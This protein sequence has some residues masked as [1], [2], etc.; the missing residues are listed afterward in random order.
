MPQIGHLD[1]YAADCL[2][3]FNRLSVHSD[4]RALQVRPCQFWPF[5]TIFRSFLVKFA[6]IF[7]GAASPRAPPIPGRTHAHTPDTPQVC[8]K[9]QT[10]PF[11]F[12]LTAPRG[13]HVH[14]ECS[15]RS[16]EKLVSA[17]SAGEEGAL[18]NG[19]LAC[20][21]P[22]GRVRVGCSDQNRWSWEVLP[23]LELSMTTNGQKL[24]GLPSRKLLSEHWSITIL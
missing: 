15:R 7:W 6:D 20:I 18:L 8:Y 5:V 9:C 21:A 3:K 4:A 2:G 1:T 22:L 19:G 17:V 12:F 14:R 23:K 11:L 13:R 16:K 24:Y 10:L